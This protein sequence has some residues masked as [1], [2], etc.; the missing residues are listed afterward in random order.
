MRE[1][2]VNSDTMETAIECCKEAGAIVKCPNCGEYDISAGD[3]TAE[4]N[5]YARA[6]NAWKMG[7]RGFRGMTREEVISEVKSALEDAGRCPR[8]STFRSS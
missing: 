4:R 3:N 2:T 8:C 7:V 6:T 5:A 1:V